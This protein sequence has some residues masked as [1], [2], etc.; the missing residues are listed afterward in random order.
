ME[1]QQ[2]ALQYRGTS[3]SESE[4]KEEVD[5][6][7][8]ETKE[9]NDVP[10]INDHA[11]VGENTVHRALEQRHISMIAIGGTIGKFL[12]LSYY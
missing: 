12:P 3:F 4:M 1:P 10:S 7:F 6:A 2:K 5:Q 9:V 8:Y 11:A